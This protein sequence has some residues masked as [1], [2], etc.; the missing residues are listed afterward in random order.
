[1]RAGWE[2]DAAMLVPRAAGRKGLRANRASLF[3]G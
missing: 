2:R 3:R 1:M